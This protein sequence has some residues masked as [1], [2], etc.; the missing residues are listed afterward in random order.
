[1]TDRSPARWLAPLALA[2]A[3]LAVVVTVSAGGGSGGGGSGGGGSGATVGS[4]TAPARAATTQ[5]TAT[6][7]QPRFYVVKPG[8]VLSAIADATGVPLSEIE[9][10]NPSVDAQALRAGQRIKLAP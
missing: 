8:D 2:V 6:T 5:T 10:L 9:R 4:A 7:R 3:A 1:M